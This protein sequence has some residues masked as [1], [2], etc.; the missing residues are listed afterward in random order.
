MRTGTLCELRETAGMPSAGPGRDLTRA[1]SREDNSPALRLAWLLHPETLGLSHLTHK[2]KWNCE[3]ESP[4]L[5]VCN[6][7]RNKPCGIG[8]VLPSLEAVQSLV[9]HGVQSS[10][11]LSVSNHGTS[12]TRSVLCFHKWEGKDTKE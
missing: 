12:Y 9:Q 8:R 5:L 4:A 7:C 2:T 10:S 1:A 6:G 11:L 3:R